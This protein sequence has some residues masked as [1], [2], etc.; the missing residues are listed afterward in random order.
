MADNS[1]R[2]HLWQKEIYSQKEK[3]F[4]EG[5][6]SPDAFA[7]ERLRLEQSRLNALRHRADLYQSLT[8]LLVQVQYAKIMERL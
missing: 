1:D 7:A 5:M 8:F 6:I 3:D 4:A 2:R